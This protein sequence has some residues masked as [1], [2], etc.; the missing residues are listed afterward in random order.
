MKKIYVVEGIRDEEILKKLNPN[1]MT[2]KTN[3]F[4]FDDEL[5]NKLIE[6]EKNYQI[7]LILDPDYPGEKIRR[8][9]SEKLSNPVNIYI[10]RDKATSKNNK[11]IG[12]EHVS[13]EDLEKILKNEITFEKNLQGDLKSSDLLELGLTGSGNSEA[14]REKLSNYYNLPKCNAK[15]LLNYL[16]KMNISKKE[17]EEVLNGS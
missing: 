17:I 4:S 3:G 5:I 9:L 11:K 7:I 6:L 1:I 10:P 13:L 15:R 8:E 14:K 2:I 12:L 16:N